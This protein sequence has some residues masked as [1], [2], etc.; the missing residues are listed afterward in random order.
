MKKYLFVIAKYNDQRMNDFDAKISP[1][2]KEYC[3]RHGFIY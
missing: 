3:E 1:R 2:N